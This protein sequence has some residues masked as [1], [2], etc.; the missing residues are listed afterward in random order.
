MRRD[1]IGVPFC[2]LGRQGSV[3]VRSGSWRQL[4]NNHQCQQQ[5]RLNRCHLHFGLFCQSELFMHHLRNANNCRCVARSLGA[6][7]VFPAMFRAFSFFFGSR[8][9]PLFFVIVS[10]T[11]STALRDEENKTRLEKLT[12]VSPMG[13][14]AQC[15]QR[16]VLPYLSLFLITDQLPDRQCRRTFLR[17]PGPLSREPSKGFFSSA[18]LLCGGSAS[19]S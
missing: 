2:L 16:T 5:L 10:T 19:N 12:A 17:L 14:S 6:L 15:G 8:R 4:Y 1:R 13:I 18:F 11:V 9:R 7:V 3:S